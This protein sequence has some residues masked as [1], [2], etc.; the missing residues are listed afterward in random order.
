MSAGEDRALAR[1][2]QTFYE[3]ARTPAQPLWAELG[4]PAREAL[5]TAVLELI[6]TQ[7]AVP[8]AK[9]QEHHTKAELYDYRLLYHAHAANEW[10]R[11]GTYPVVKSRRHP[12]GEECFGGGWFIVVATLP[13]GQVSNH[14]RNE[15]WD[16]FAVPEASVPPAFDGH[17]P[18][19]AADRLRAD[20][21]ALPTGPSLEA[22]PGPAGHPT[23]PHRST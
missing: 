6:R 23:A 8:E 14:Y 4:V 12:E 5:A 15:F 1:E 16:Y 21:T 20:L 19:V 13:G 9:E 2:V 11:H 10:A 3:A 18:P 17:T 7:G 22:A